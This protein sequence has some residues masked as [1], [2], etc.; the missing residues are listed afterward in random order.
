RQRRTAHLLMH[1][2]PTP[3]WQKRVALVVGLRTYVQV[4]GE[5]VTRMRAMQVAAE[6]QVVSDQAGFSE[7][8]QLLS[9]LAAQRAVLL[10]QQSKVTADLRNQ[11]ATDRGAVVAR[12]T[13]LVAHRDELAKLQAE[14]QAT[15]AKQAEVEGRLFEVERRVGQTLD[16]NA[17]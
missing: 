13:Q 10:Y 14:V 6:Q 9:N 17:E 3:A 4:V 8:Y 16:R 12:A 1:L 7:E 2:D 15:L 5:H 11:R